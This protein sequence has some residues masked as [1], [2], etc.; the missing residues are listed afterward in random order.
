MGL[1]SLA[2]RVGR[3]FSGYQP[4]QSL[5]RLFD[6]RPVQCS[7]YV[8]DRCNLDCAYCTEYDNSRPHPS[9]EDLK[10]WMRKIRELGTV[11]LALVGG[12]PLLH[13]EVVELVRFARELGFAT[14]LTTN[15]FLLTPALV[16]RLEEAGLQVMQISVDRMT[17]SAVTRKS[18]K[19]VLPKLDCFRDSRI[20]LHITG[21]ACEDTLAESREVLETGL[22]RGVP[23]E[24]RLV[25][26]DPSRRFRVGRG[27]AAALEALLEEMIARKRKGERIHT[28]EA[29][30]QYQLA[31]LRGQ[32]VEWTCRAGYKL[33]FVSAQGRFWICSMVH[34]DKHILDVTPE[35]LVANDRPKACQDGC[36]VYCAVG[37]SLIVEQ[38]VRW[39]SREVA[40]RLRRLPATLRPPAGP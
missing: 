32:R 1:S 31:L 4:L 36:G 40:A 17:P 23:T 5:R 33:F 22:R 26:A 12:E 25:H 39:L 35:D 19:T 29:V 16:R 24:L 11:R 3:E 6:A 27:D 2:A 28:S 18:F 20:A 38:P 8:T 7:L 15:G 13:P 10:L 34:T 9:A 37:T 21:V 14:S 30:L